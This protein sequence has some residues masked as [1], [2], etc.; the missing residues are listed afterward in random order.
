[1]QTY[2]DFNTLSYAQQLTEAGFTAEQA[3]IQAKTLKK[4]I[5]SNIATKQDIL[6]LENFT[7]EE[8]L[9]LEKT[10]K[11]EVLR[12]EKTM[13]EDILR[14]EKAI[15]D[16]KAE[17]IKWVAGMLVAQAAIVATLVKLL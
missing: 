9:K 5:E 11:E 14:L 1:M 8:I 10:T 4:I 16:T 3:E 12:L 13:K 6:R 15:S 2:I 17:I 7:K